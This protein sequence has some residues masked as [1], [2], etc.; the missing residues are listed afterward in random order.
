MFM[1]PKRRKAKNA[2]GREGLR[3]IDCLPRGVGK[4]SVR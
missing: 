1:G 2:E 3:I 4:G